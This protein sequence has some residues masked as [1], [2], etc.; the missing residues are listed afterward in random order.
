[1]IFTGADLVFNS[2][3]FQGLVYVE[4]IRTTLTP[5][6]S[7][8]QQE[9]PGRTGVR[10]GKRKVG[11]R[12][13]EVDIRMIESARADVTDVATIVA[14]RLMSDGLAKLATR[15][16]RDRWWMAVYVGEPELKQFHETGFATLEFLAP[17]GAMY[18]DEVTETLSAGANTVTATGTWESEPEIEIL[19]NAIRSEVSA[20][21]NGKTVTAKRLTGTWPSGTKIKFVTESRSVYVNGVLDNSV[22]LLASRYGVLKPGGNNISLVGGGGTLK[23]FPRWL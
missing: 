8:P 15:R 2:F 11:A 1:M 21:V 18:S 7:Y 5:Q 14:G 3:N 17:G 13:I 4:E 10:L 9:I 22:V 6:I 12:M 23:Y 20:T 19:L 16:D